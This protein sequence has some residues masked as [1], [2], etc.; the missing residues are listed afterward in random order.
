MP[1]IRTLRS[2]S[3]PWTLPLYS[4]IAYAVYVRNERAFLAPIRAQT[5]YCHFRWAGTGEYQAACRQALDR[6]GYLP[7]YEP[8]LLCLCLLSPDP[9][10]QAEV[11]RHHLSQ[12]AQDTPPVKL[13]HAWGYYRL[14]EYDRAL[15]ALPTDGDPLTTCL[16]PLLAAMVHHRLGHDDEAKRQLDLAQQR[17]DNRI[18]SVTGPPIARLELPERPVCRAMVGILRDEA[19]ALIESGGYA[20]N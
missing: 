15:K 8:R 13:A 10:I 5:G 7:E 12:L 14:A 19:K 18:P 11:L 6:F 9:V 1:L 16:A 2:V 3:I 20:V 4:I 17:T